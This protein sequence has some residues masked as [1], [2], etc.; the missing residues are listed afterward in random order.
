[1][2][3]VFL[4]AL[5]DALTRLNQIR[6]WRKGAPSVSVSDREILRITAQWARK[7]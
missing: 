1:M 2:D 4:I 7:G 5:V 6:K 3:T